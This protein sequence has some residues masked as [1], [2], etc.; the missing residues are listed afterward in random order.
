MDMAKYKT[1]NQLRPVCKSFWR[2]E[3]TLHNAPVAVVSKVLMVSA[4]EF[5]R[6]PLDR[7][8]RLRA[9]EKPPLGGTRQGLQLDRPSQV[10]RIFKPAAA[11][12][13]PHLKARS[14]LRVS[15]RSDSQCSERL[16]RIVGGG[17]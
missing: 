2:S 15:K 13:V 7:L 1:E 16:K 8:Y 14:L 17:A 9:R 10:H 5:A 3:P 6:A 4:A 12:A 11:A